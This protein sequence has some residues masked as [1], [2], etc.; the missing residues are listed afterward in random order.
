MGSMLETV[1]PCGYVTSEILSGIGMQGIG[2][3]PGICHKCREIVSVATHQ[4]GMPPDFSS[5]QKRL[6]CSKCGRKPQMLE[7]IMQPPP[8]TEDEE[9]SFSHQGN[10]DPEAI[11]ICPNCDQKTLKLYA[12]GI[13]D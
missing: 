3:E 1:C 13:W 2:H 4:I 7:L 11:Y 8:E 9:F 6:R 5:K 10:L 12:M